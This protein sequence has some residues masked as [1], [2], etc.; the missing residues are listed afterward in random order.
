MRTR[1][2]DL[3]WI[4]LVALLLVPVALHI[5]GHGGSPGARGRSQTYEGG[6]ALDSLLA[7]G[8]GEPVILNFW[9]TWCTPCIRELPEIDAALAGSGTPVVVIAVDIG[10]PGPE[11]FRRFASGAGLSFPLIWVDPETAE[12]LEERYRLPGLLPSTIVLDGRGME[13][14]RLSGARDRDFFEDLFSGLGEAGSRVGEDGMP[15][16]GGEIHIN[17]VGTPGDPAYEA[18]AAEAEA[19]AGPGGVSTFDPTVPADSIAMT[20]LSL[21]FPGHPYAQ[22]CV[23]DACGRPSTDPEALRLTVEALGT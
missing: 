19:L 20:G 18:L 17:L 9:A 11:P 15:P 8:A 12:G 6:A 13:M 10:D 7:A 4:G 2:P 3:E 1:L 16:A 14:A 22:A 23:G 5:A 21:P